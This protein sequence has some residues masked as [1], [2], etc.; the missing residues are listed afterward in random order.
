MTF[1]CLCLSE[2]AASRCTSRGGEPCQTRPGILRRHGATGDSL[3]QHVRLC[4]TWNRIRALATEIYD[5]CRSLL[6]INQT[7]LNLNVAVYP[8]YSKSSQSS[9]GGLISN[10]YC[11]ERLW[12]RDFFPTAAQST[13]VGQLA[14]R[15]E[16]R[17]LRSQKAVLSRMRLRQITQG[18]GSGSRQFGSA[19]AKRSRT[20][21]FLKPADVLRI[22]NYAAISK[23]RAGWRTCWSAGR[24]D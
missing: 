4:C 23:E 17:Q 7:V 21:E 3:I 12:L 16:D 5:C 1:W 19:N 8:N 2:S 20:G 14:V 22:A 11:Q 10:R 13:V 24:G 9:V 6:A 18:L 15:N